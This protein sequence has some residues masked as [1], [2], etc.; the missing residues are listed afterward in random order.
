MFSFF[1]KR[2][3]TPIE[4]RNYSTVYFVLSTILFLGTMWSVVD[5]VT[6]R[7]PWKEY[8]NEYRRV[9]VQRFTQ[10]RDD[11]IAAFDS[12]GYVEAFA[13]F[14]ETEK[15][16]QSREYI[17]AVQSFALIKDSLV[18][19]SRNFTF[20]K[21]VADEAY[22]FYQRA[23]KEGPNFEK[24][25]K[26]LRE[27]EREMAMLGEITS[28]MERQKDALR[29]FI[30]VVDLE[31]KSAQAKY[32]SF[33]AD[34]NTWNDKIER[35]NDAPLEI[36][37]VIL[38]DFERTNFGTI[39]ARIDRCQTCHL[40]WR[41]YEAFNDAPQP[42]TAHPFPELLEKHNPENVGCTSCHNGQGPALETGFA[43]SRHGD[44]NGDHYWEKSLLHGKETYASCNSCHSTQ[45]QLKNAEYFNKGRQLI[46]E[47]GCF[48]CHE[49]KTYADVP[50]IGPELNQLSA[51]TTPEWLFRWVRNPKDFNPHT[52]M[53]NFQF[54]NDSAEAIAAFLWDLSKNVALPNT[55]NVFGGNMERGK[56]LVDEVGCKGCH[57]IDG[58]ERVR[59]LRGKS[60]DIAPELSRIGSKTTPQWL[61]E[62]I[63][64][65]KQ[66]RADAQMPNLR[67]T[68]QEAKDI[69]AYLQTLNDKRQF[70]FRQ[71]DLTS[72]EKITFGEKLV[73]EYGCHG[74]HD[75]RGM[76][77]EGR[78][79]V[80][81]SNFGRKRVDELDFGDTKFTHHEQTWD[82]WVE[83]KLN[84]ARMYTT[85]RIIS[86]MPVFTF[87][88]SEIVMIR[89]QLRG[90]VKD[91]AEAQYQE[92][93][94]ARIQALQAGRKL[95]TKLN[96]IGCHTLEEQGGYVKALFEDEGMAPPPITGEGA[97]VQEM[98]LHNFL[99]KPSP[100]RPWLKLRMPTFEFSGAEIN[101][102]TKYFLALSKK[103]LEVRDYA[104]LQPSQELLSAG[105]NLFD[106]NQCLSCHTTSSTIPEGK[107]PGDLAPNLALAHERLKPEWIID[108]LKNPEAIQPGTRMPQ[109][110]PFD[111][112]GN[113]SAIYTEYLDGDA[114]KQM[115]AIRDYLWNLGKQLP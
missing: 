96:C 114:H 73:R 88:D 71:L 97:K 32:E 8:Q 27:L 102:I 75:I 28:R 57:V 91:T 81:L 115:I 30:A 107:S 33:F 18:D 61:Y 105:K 4:V 62:W 99:N 45:L 52:R 6:V 66:F 9:A 44:P 10:L 43:H 12:V 92:T 110:F 40:G 38:N 50:K 36:K 111:E 72:K 106:D 59:N 49:I 69:V 98:W 100:I 63:R 7:R 82:L 53:P 19:A 70:E 55:Q 24:E 51:K 34:I 94:N 37:Q 35:A 22:Y 26:H 5:E 77:K 39:K 68:E 109:F 87:A 112:K 85:E 78:V 86:K 2:Y 67:L 113:P 108:W 58:D 16:L 84:N 3:N 20:A 90:F 64:N 31:V 93:N 48:G 23:K 104:S 103:E 1:K 13:S 101:T 79:S 14:R 15:K 83:G 47:A 46:L 42:F 41:E 25:E 29:K 17:N 89:S 95:T 11:A 76:E 60:Y 80:S 65:P 74:C 21:S 54:G 56:Q